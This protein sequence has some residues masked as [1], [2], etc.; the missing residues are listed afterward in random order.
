VSKIASCD[1]LIPTAVYTYLSPLTEGK[2]IG[3]GGSFSRNGTFT[4]I[5]TRNA[6]VY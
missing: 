5:S 3:K 4:A 1:N 6:S 2:D